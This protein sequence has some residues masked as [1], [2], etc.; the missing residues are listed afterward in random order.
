LIHR[1]PTPAEKIE[2]T[3]AEKY[4]PL[5]PPEL[6][7]EAV[8]L[9]AHLEALNWVVK[10]GFKYTWHAV[11]GEEYESFHYCNMCGYFFGAGD[12]A[13]DERTG[14]YVDSARHGAHG[15]GG[16]GFIYDPVLDLMG[17]N[18][19]EY[20]GTPLRLYPRS[21]FALHFP[22]AADTL[23]LV[24][25]V[26]STVERE[27]EWELGL[28]W[29]AFI[30]RGMAVAVGNEFITDFVYNFQV[31]SPD[32][33]RWFY[34]GRTNSD[35]IEAADVDGKYGVIGRDGSVV[36][37][38]EF[39]GVMIID[40]WTAFVQ[41]G[42]RWGIVA[43][44]DGDV[45]D[46]RPSG[47]NHTYIDG[48]WL[49]ERWQVVYDDEYKEFSLQNSSGERFLGL[50]FEALTNH[51]GRNI[52]TTNG[53]DVFWIRA[54]NEELVLNQVRLSRDWFGEVIL[55]NHTIDDLEDNLAEVLSAAI[56]IM[57]LTQRYLNDSGRR[58]NTENSFIQFTMPYNGVIP[59]AVFSFSLAAV[60]I[61][62]HEDDWGDWVYFE[63]VNV[64][65]AWEVHDVTE[66]IW[67]QRR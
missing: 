5:P 60:G 51:G 49:N 31:D 32:H 36:L 65:G 11:G 53:E 61:D 12:F 30:G 34:R 23:M 22:E 17:V 8:E 67:E 37:P 58:I 18:G 2:E 25:S 27:H 20:S 4:E 3:P 41:Y 45:P 59:E 40:R 14:L 47:E 6:I 13:V 9:P 10:P 66:E 29:Q 43:F 48:D 35:K 39:E 56:N 15:G 19:S 46:F 33:W 24:R 21:E 28:P 1:P 42:E 38:F 7:Y 55:Y 50:S 16:L 54:V 64:N 44:E 52:R 62:A 63:A 26:D 57:Y